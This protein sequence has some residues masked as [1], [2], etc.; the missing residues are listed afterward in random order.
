MR[1]A[2]YRKAQQVLICDLFTMRAPFLR[3][4]CVARCFASID[5]LARK[6]FFFKKRNES[7]Q[8]EPVASEESARSRE[9][10]Q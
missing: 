1:A 7:K 3:E 5:L 4:I 6:L 9:G 2:N 10:E 8:F